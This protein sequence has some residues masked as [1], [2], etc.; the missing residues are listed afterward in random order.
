MADHFRAVWSVSIDDVICSTSLDYEQ[1]AGGDPG[2][3]CQ[4][5]A[6]S[7]QD[8]LLTP[9]RALLSQGTRVENI[10]VFKMDGNTRPAWKGN[11]Q[12]TYGT[13]TGS[14]PISAQNC[15]IIN[16]R[17]A[18]GELKR[19]GRMF[20]SGVDKSELNAGIWNAATMTGK[21]NNF[22]TFAQNIPAGG[23][24]G[25]AG[26]LVVRRNWID[27]IKQEPPVYVTVNQW[28]YAPELGTQHKRKGQLSGYQP[29][30]DFPAP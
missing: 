28:D 30:L 8:S 3:I 18:E 25:W 23:V 21:V 29:D 10:K 1:T 12:S 26:F 2:T 24:D 7:I 11:F 14:D 17:N 19:P 27:K 4:S 13:D 5:A 9:F 16:H 22:M 15:L 20:V 6:V